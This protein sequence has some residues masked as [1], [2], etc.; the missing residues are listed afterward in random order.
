MAVADFVENLGLDARVGVTTRGSPRK[1]FARYVIW[2]RVELTTACC[3]CCPVRRTSNRSLS[4]ER[5]ILTSRVGVEQ[6]LDSLARSANQVNIGCC[7]HLFRRTSPVPPSSRQCTPNCD[8]D[9][10]ARYR[11]RS[12]MFLLQQESISA[13]GHYFSLPTDLIHR[14]PLVPNQRRWFGYHL[15]TS[16]SLNA[17]RMVRRFWTCYKRF[18]EIIEDS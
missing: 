2:K 12:L 7:R 15:S 14:H 18:V 16:G 13:S 4:R 3:C 10:D 1:S 8:R 17:T 6:Q 5:P 11:R 9:D